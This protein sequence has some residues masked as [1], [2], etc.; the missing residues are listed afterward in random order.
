LG[1]FSSRDVLEQFDYFFGQTR[2]KFNSAFSNQD[3]QEHFEYFFGQTREK[4][5][6]VL[7]EALY[8]RKDSEIHQA[9]VYPQEILECTDLA[10]LI[11]WFLQPDVFKQQYP[12]YAG[13]P[14]D[15]IAYMASA[16]LR[17]FMNVMER[18]SDRNFIEAEK[19]R[20]MI[21]ADM[22]FSLDI[23]YIKTVEVGFRMVEEVDQ[24]GRSFSPKRL[25]VVI[26]SRDIQEFVNGQDRLFAEQIKKEG[27]PGELLE[28]DAEDGQKRYYRVYEQE[29]KKF[30]KV[31]MS[32]PVMRIDPE[33][34][35]F[36]K[37][38]DVVTTALIYSG[39]DHY[40]HL[41]DALTIILSFDR[42]KEVTDESRWMICFAT[43]EGQ[44]AFK[45]F[46][47]SRNPKGMIKTEDASENRFISNK[48]N[49]RKAADST[50]QFK[51]GQEFTHTMYVSYITARVK[52][53]ENDRVVKYLQ[54]EKMTLETQCQTLRNLLRTNLSKHS[55]SSHDVY[56]SQSY[57]PLLFSYYFPPEFFGD[58]F[59][60]FQDQGFMVENED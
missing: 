45:S 51:Q 36:V 48:R 8:Y 12:Q 47:Y 55:P 6:K 54:T 28:V 25:D 26:D 29:K 16:F 15:Q 20:H 31:R 3:V 9:C 43:Q 39:D 2:D 17:E 34:G 7:R 22:K 38:K 30:K 40:V 57:W 19:R 60:A 50:K 4:F 49:R 33:T 5:N 13:V 59:K 21:E 37:E 23:R 32:I 11:E 42:G 44:E 46:I 56:K 18:M 1:V 24:Q 41:K 14:N 27:R 35:L 52:R 58:K 10:K 53:K